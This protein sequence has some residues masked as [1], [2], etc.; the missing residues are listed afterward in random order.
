MTSRVLVVG[1]GAREH[2]LAWRLA[3]EGAHAI[4]APGNPLMTDVADVRPRVTADDFDGLVALARTERVD[5]AVVGPEAPLAGGL[6]DTFA[7]AGVP[8]FG[9][10][11]AAAKLESSKAFAREVCDS[12]GVV[13]ARGRAFDSVRPA[14]AFAE[15]LGGRAVVKADGLAA[16]KGVTICGELV[17]AESALRDALEGDRFGAAGRTVVVEEVLRGVE[18]SV[19]AI[20]H[21][22][23]AFLLPAARDHKRL[24]EDDRGP[25]TGGMGAYSPVPELEDDA[26]LALRHDV[27]LPVLAEMRRRGTPFHGALFAGLMLTQ[28][29]PRVLEFNVR[30]GDPE[31]QVILPRLGEP[32][33]PLLLGTRQASGPLVSTGGG[34]TVGIGLACAGYP[35]GARLGDRVEGLDEARRSGALIFGAG[36]NAPAPGSSELLTS[37]GRVLT[38]AASGSDVA[39]AADRAYAAAGL[40]TFAG[41]QMRRDIGRSLA[42]TVGGA[43]A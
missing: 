37:G 33:L 2:A 12:A 28:D 31:T 41:R 35:D 26:M 38:V 13:M 19:I 23:D 40:I 24:L 3:D 16:G 5:L 11:A 25:N 42:G 4:V 14:V 8:C 21:S 30:F 17:E 43:V 6:G 18:A 27:F 22:D 32:L 1:S 29:G 7:E 39:E 15:S 36:V 20:C 34:A 9:P 10:T